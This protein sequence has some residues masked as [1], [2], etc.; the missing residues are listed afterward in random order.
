M[1]IKENSV[2][3]FD[4]DDTLYKE[5][6]FLKSAYQEIAFKINPSLKD[7]IFEDMMTSYFLRNNV[8]EEVILK[9]QSTLTKEELLLT[10]RNHFPKIQLSENVEY[11]LKQLKKN[12][13]IIG[14]ITDG[15]SITQRNK[16]KSLG[17]EPYLDDVIISEE[18]GSEKPNMNNYLYYQKKYSQKDFFYYIGDN[19]KKDFI[20]PNKLKW[21]TLGLIDDGNNIHK[22]DLTLNKLFHP[23]Y[24]INNF[25]EVTF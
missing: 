11:I 21:I 4:L 10:Y 24:F 13:I 1:K 7:K 12:K 3:V 8:F 16:I 9:Y 15:R 6:D 2:V 18:F 14:L 19:L 22:Q 23:S 5:I 17:I 20:S 25:K